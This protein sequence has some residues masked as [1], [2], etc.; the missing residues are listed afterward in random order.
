MYKKYKHTVNTLS[1]SFYHEQVCL[2]HR[3]ED[4]FRT[5]TKLLNYDINDI[6]LDYYRYM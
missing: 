1:P 2:Y 3:H 4:L 6:E 5:T